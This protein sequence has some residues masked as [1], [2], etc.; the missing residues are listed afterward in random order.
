[1]LNLTAVD[2]D[3]GSSGVQTALPPRDPPSG[4]WS[5]PRSGLLTISRAL[6]DAAQFRQAR[7]M[8]LYRRRVPSLFT[9][10]FALIHSST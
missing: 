10:G 6:P 2:F 4:K 9:S 7:I 1:M 8:A 3:S 5:L